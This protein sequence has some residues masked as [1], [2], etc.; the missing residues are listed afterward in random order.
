[1]K[2][3]LVF[4]AVLAAL[5]LGD[6]QSASAQLFSYTPSGYTGY[7][8]YG[9]YGSPGYAPRYSYTAP[10][11]PPVYTYAVPGY[12]VLPAAGY[13]AV[14]PVAPVYGLNRGTPYYP[15]LYGARYGYGSAVFGGGYGI[16]GGYGYPAYG[17]YGGS[18]GYGTA[19]YNQAGFRP[20]KFSGGF[21][22]SLSNGSSW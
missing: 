5:L 14:A 19:G 15:P 22:L 13:Y 2:Q 11:N 9:G 17:G 21:G 10:V 16:G 7:L 20:T 1:M 3:T 6:S 18:Y 8:P 4:A 12:P